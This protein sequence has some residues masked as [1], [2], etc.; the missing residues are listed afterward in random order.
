LPPK[1]RKV[2]LPSVPS[3]SSSF[4]VPSMVLMG[5]PVPVCVLRGVGA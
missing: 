1:P 2:S 4:G 5:V 3:S